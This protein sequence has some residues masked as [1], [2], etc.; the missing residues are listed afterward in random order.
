MITM[1]GGEI[2]DLLIKAG[3][4]AIAMSMG[5][6]SVVNAWINTSLGRVFQG[7]GTERVSGGT[8]VAA[9]IN[10]M[11]ALLCLATVYF[12]YVAVAAFQAHRKGESLDRFKWGK[13]S[14]WYEY[15]GG[16]SGATF[17]SLTLI[18]TKVVGLGIYVVCRTVGMLVMALVVD[19][20]GFLGT[21]VTKVTWPRLLGVFICFLGVLC[22][23]WESFNSTLSPGIIVVFVILAIF[24]GT[25]LIVQATINVKLSNSL[26][27]S[28]A[29]A[30]IVNFSLS[31]IVLTIVSVVWAAAMDN[32]ANA[33]LHPATGRK[34]SEPLEFWRL[35]GGPL[36]SCFISAPVFITPITGTA[37]YWIAFIAGSLILSVIFDAMGLQGEV[38]PFTMSRGF[39]LALTLL[40]AIAVQIITQRDKA[41]QQ[42]KREDDKENEAGT[43]DS[44]KAKMLT[45]PSAP[46]APLQVPEGSAV[47]NDPPPTY[48]DKVVGDGATDGSWEQVAQAPADANALHYIALH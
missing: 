30:I 37:L 8:I 1:S 23:S 27:G 21:P 18:V 11:V 22:M 34:E 20:V 47:D 28:R 6:F 32:V 38:Q 31:I 13:P 35:L 42:R 15:C 46:S 12:T 7:H 5:M 19:H 16:L 48:E 40:G 36:S 39:G 33:I 41:R 2:H 4:F 29:R 44:A 45:T 10:F 25:L 24:A 43:S 26:G 17:L 3:L 9:A 14:R